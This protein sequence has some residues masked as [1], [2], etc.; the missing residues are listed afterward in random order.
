MA[1]VHALAFGA[2]VADVVGVSRTLLQ[3]LHHVV[4]GELGAL[5]AVSRYRE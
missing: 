2:A 4:V 3:Q 5:P 1:G